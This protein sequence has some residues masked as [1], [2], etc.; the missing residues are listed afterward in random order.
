MGAGDG[1]EALRVRIVLGPSMH[2]GGVVLAC[3]AALQDLAGLVRQADRVR[4]AE[5][6][7]RKRLLRL[8][9]DRY[10]VWR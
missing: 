2:R 4:E 7:L 8:W 10:T 1:I 5:A 3:N 9:R 6:R